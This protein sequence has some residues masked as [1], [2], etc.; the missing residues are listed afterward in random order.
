MRVTKRC[1]PKQRHRSKVFLIEPKA[2]WNL[3]IFGGVGG[4]VDVYGPGG[5]L[6]FSSRN[7]NSL[8]TFLNGMRGSCAGAMCNF[9][10]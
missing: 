8:F 3:I 5:K 1:P 6:F 7:L 9:L 4:S 10:T 2:L